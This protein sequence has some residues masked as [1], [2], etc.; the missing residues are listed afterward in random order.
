[1][2]HY[3][4]VAALRLGYFFAFLNLTC[5]D[6]MQRSVDNGLSLLLS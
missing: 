6:F 2:A 3:T 5:S 1:M 4:P